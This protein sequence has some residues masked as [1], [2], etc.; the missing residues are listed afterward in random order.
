MKTRLVIAWATSVL[1]ALLVGVGLAGPGTRAAFVD[2]VEVTQEIR[3]GRLAVRLTA[4]DG[5][6]L[7]DASD[8]H[9]LT[10]TLAGTNVDLRHEATLRNDGTLEV[11][12][13]TLTMEPSPADIAPAMAKLVLEVS[14]AAPDGRTATESHP[15]SYW[16]AGPRTVAPDVGLAPGRDIIVGLHLTGDLPTSAL[17]RQTE[18]TYRFTASTK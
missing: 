17:D 4:V 5:T 18:L 1:A 7:P 3:T 12:A 10:D 16:L 11:G 13:L 8:S 9:H 15:L 6:L 2:S 14:Y